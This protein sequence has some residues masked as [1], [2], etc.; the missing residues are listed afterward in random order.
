MMPTPHPPV[1]AVTR[2][3]AQPD[4]FGAA[5]QAAG[6]NIIRIPT[7]RTEPALDSQP[8]AD[9]L[10][11]LTTFDWILF[12]SGRT[13]DAWIALDTANHLASLPHLR[14]AAVGPTT[15][16]RLAVLGIKAHVIGGG[17]GARAVAEQMVASTGSDM[18]GTRI[19]WPRS[20]LADASLAKDLTS[21]GAEVDHPIAYR[22]LLHTPANIEEYQRLLLQ[23]HVAATVFFA[24][25]AAAGLA[26][27][28]GSTD[29]AALRGRTEIAAV[30]DTTAVALARLGAPAGTIGSSSVEQFAAAL[31]RRL[32]LNPR[33]MQ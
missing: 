7:T 2:S 19:L 18:P 30:G 1:V 12:T 33:V 15:A 5:M 27:A 22:T 21:L 29:L 4:P 10:A 17:E 28:L 20:D 16:G 14:I 26:R 25:S 13:V 31:I 8:L 32:A 6:V 3:V 9:A 24:P 23:S 11:R